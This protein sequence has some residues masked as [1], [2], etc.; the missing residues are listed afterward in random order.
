MY[1]TDPTYQAQLAQAHRAGQ[2]EAAERH[3]YNR[4]FRGEHPKRNVFAMVAGAATSL[5]NAAV[6]AFAFSRHPAASS[7]SATPR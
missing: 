5:A 2:I 3:R 1:I 6:A 4:Q 7:R